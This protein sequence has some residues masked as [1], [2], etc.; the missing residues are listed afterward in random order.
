VTYSGPSRL[1]SNYGRHYP[2]QQH[3]SPGDSEG[4]SEAQAWNVKGNRSDG[5]VGTLHEQEDS[6]RRDRGDQ[7]SQA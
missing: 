6:H 3:Q 7:R 4:H 2:R 5:K 1:S